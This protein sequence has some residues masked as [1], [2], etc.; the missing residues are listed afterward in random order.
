MYIQNSFLRAVVYV[1]VVTLY[2]MIVPAIW[3]SIPIFI[4]AC[5]SP[6]IIV[7]LPLFMLAIFL[8]YKQRWFYQKIHI[9]EAETLPRYFF[10][11]YLPVYF[12]L[13]YTLL[14]MYASS[15][16][17]YTTD[18]LMTIYNIAFFSHLHY[19]AWM[20]PVIFLN[21]LSGNSVFYLP[22]IAP[23]V[24]ELIALIVC[25]NFMSKVPA[26]SAIGKRFGVTILILLFLAP[27]AW[28]VHFY[29]NNYDNVLPRDNEIVKVREKPET[30]TMIL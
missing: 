11:R 10:V 8:I 26:S 9:M 18:N 6:V 5:F 30:N 2:W 22:F 3:A 15:Y 13:L 23:L 1:V 25:I 12:P 28:F 20:L 21:L 24:T 14:T 19:I 29:S 27:T 7:A 17:G 4:L 16:I